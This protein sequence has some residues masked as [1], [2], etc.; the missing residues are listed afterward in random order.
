[1]TASTPYVKMTLPRDTVVW[2]EVEAGAVPETGASTVSLRSLVGRFGSV[3][4]PIIAAVSLV[5]WTPPTAV[6]RFYSSEETTTT[7]MLDLIWDLDDVWILTRAR[8]TQA[9]ID[10]LNALLNLNV[11]EG[12]SVDLADES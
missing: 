1:M 11:A 2:E 5:G 4:A 7:G 3:A 6:R 8:T 9:E 12:S 10:S